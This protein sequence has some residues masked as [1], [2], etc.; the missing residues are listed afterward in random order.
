MMGT[1]QRKFIP[2][3]PEDR[4]LRKNF[5]EVSDARLE[6]AFDGSL[7]VHGATGLRYLVV[8]PIELPG[9]KIRLNL[10]C[11]D[12]KP[13]IQKYHDMQQQLENLAKLAAGVFELKIEL[14]AQNKRLDAVRQHLD[15]F[16]DTAV[17]AFE[18]I[19]F[20]DRKWRMIKYSKGFQEA[21][22][23]DV[24]IIRSGK[25]RIDEFFA[26][27]QD[28]IVSMMNRMQS[29]HVPIQSLKVT[30]PIDATKRML[31]ISSFAETDPDQPAF[32]CEVR[33]CPSWDQV[34]MKPIPS[35]TNGE[36]PNTNANSV[37]KDSRLVFAEG[38]L[39]TTEF[40]L[41][42]TIKKTKLHSRKGVTYHSVRRWRASIK[43]CQIAA[44]KALKKQPNDIL[45]DQAANELAKVAKTLFG[46]P[47][48]WVVASVA[49]GNSGKNC[50]AKL[51]AI[52]LATLLELEYFEAFDPIKTTGSSHP[53]RNVERPKMQLSRSTDRPILLIDDV[54]TTGTHIYEAVNLLSQESPSVVSLAW[55]AG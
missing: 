37:T 17:N 41:N 15:Q 1:L 55:I 25:C 3:T 50:L 20:L 9:S 32:M 27:E 2:N 54:A 42:T 39:V 31:V 19:V 53:R 40:L 26:H 13:N 16:T 33:G 46:Q 11:G 10:I 23:T 12:R 30:W 14:T 44:L 28:L 4:N 52:R 18:S 38:S 45:V 24:D 7:F 6:P 29:D 49:C 43:D 34:M 21:C 35:S 51:L 47:N 5:L 8:C 36:P 22:Q 48:D